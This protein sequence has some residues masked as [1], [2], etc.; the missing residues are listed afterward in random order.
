MMNYKKMNNKEN[1]NEVHINLM[2]NEI[3]KDEEIIKKNKGK[4]IRHVKKK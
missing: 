3:Q 2:D 4:E 1:Q